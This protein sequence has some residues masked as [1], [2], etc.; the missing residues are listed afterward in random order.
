M[1]SQPLW[2]SQGNYD[3]AMVHK[4]KFMQRVSTDHKHTQKIINKRHTICQVHFNVC[5]Q[6][7]M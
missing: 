6:E 7:I 3:R 1:P 2:S 5:A 4:I